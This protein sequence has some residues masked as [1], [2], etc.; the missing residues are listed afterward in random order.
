MPR[1]NP[2]KHADWA[3]AKMLFFQGA[4][5][6]TIAQQIGVS[7]SALCQR[8]YRE[9]WIDSK[10]KATQ[11]GNQLVQNRANVALLSLEER[12]DRWT[13]ALAKNVE[14]SI[15]DLSKVKRP[16]SLKKW[17]EYENVMHV[18]TKRGRATF[19]LDAKT[20]SVTV[21]CGMIGLPKAQ[22]TEIIDIEPQEQL[23]ESTLDC[24]SSEQS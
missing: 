12:A 24:E 20:A 6:A 22:P 5:Y 8:V 21:N 15:S 17:Q 11:I 19:G 9:N 7:Q 14:E 16:K 3:L 23:P 1:G 4:T 18:H 10:T 2:L 13:D